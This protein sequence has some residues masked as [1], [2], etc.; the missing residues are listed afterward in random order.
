[1]SR[2]AG[3]PCGL[4]AASYAVHWVY[5]AAWVR[6]L[7]GSL[8]GG[9]RASF[10]TLSVNPLAVHGGKR[11]YSSFQIK[12]GLAALVGIVPSLSVGVRGVSLVAY[13]RGERLYIQSSCWPA[14]CGVSIQWEGF[15]CK[16]FF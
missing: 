12:F 8:P 9:Q 4:L 2:L 1:M 5:Q 6:E 11:A 15:F 7:G 10:F 3:S 13:R 16:H 14:Q